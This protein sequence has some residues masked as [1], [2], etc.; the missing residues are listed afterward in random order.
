MVNVLIEKV[1]GD[2]FDNVPYFEG[3]FD[4]LIAVLMRKDLGRSF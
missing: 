3:I 1:L 2:L 4:A